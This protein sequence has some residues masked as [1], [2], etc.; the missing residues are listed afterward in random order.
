VHPDCEKRGQG[1]TYLCIAHG[2]GKRCVQPGCKKSA[3]GK[4][5]LCIAHGGG[6]RCVH[7]DC[8]KGAQGKTDLCA[9]HGGGK[10]CVH[11]DCEK[12]AQGKTDLCKRHFS[13]SL[14]L[15]P[16]NKTEEIVVKF[17]RQYFKISREFSFPE[18]KRRYDFMVET[19]NKKIF[20]EVD[21]DQHFWDLYETTRWPCSLKADVEKQ[22]A[23]Y[24]NGYSMVRIR[25]AWVWKN[26]EKQEWRDWL[27][28]AIKNAC[29][30]QFVVRR[31]DIVLYQ[32]H[33]A[34]ETD[35]VLV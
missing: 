4:T 11:P 27:L 14:G 35:I 28:A 9:A 2:G 12:C 21:G 34:G 15:P 20:I 22:E 33:T 3:L 17:L 13:E 31:E 32:Y 29:E 6:K 7:P 1:T 26:K 30:H 5:N 16:R 19:G 8:K 18:S 10:R 23:A 24:Q 25:Q